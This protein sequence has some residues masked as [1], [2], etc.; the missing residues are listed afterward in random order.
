MWLV[1]GNWHIANRGKRDACF[2]SAKRKYSL[3]HC[4]VNVYLFIYFHFS[5]FF[6]YSR[7][8]EWVVRN[9]HVK[10]DSEFFSARCTDLSSHCS[11]YPTSQ[12]HSFQ[13]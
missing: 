10:G 6:A 1:G 13:F 8:K 3:Q 7:K 5:F 11:N 2:L 12:S 4:S 9:D